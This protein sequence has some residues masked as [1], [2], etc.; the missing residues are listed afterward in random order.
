MKSSKENIKNRRNIS[1]IRKKNRYSD[2][3]PSQTRMKQKE[4]IM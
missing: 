2:K 4:A 1:K 3:E